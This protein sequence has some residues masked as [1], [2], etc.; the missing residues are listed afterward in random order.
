M[1]KMLRMLAGNV[2]E[3]YTGV[4]II[5]SLRGR[6]QYKELSECTRVCFYPVTDAE[7]DAYIQ[8]G[9]PMDK[10]GSYGIQGIGGR[11]VQSISGDYQNVVGLPVARLYQE[12]KAME[13]D[14]RDEMEEKMWIPKKEADER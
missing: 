12:L 8:S 11:F 6:R 5:L 13:K 1:Q 2:H 9:E 4:T 10:A 14:E 7:I 3:V